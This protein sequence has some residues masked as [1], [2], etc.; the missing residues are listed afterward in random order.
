M[1]YKDVLN[2]W[3][4]IKGLEIRKSSVQNYLQCTNNWIIPSLGNVP[5]QNIKRDDLQN[6]ILDFASN[7]KHNTVINIT[8]PLFGSFKWAGENNF[9]D[10]NPCKGVKIPK[11]FSEKEINVF[12]P[13][14]IK[15]ILEAANGY[16]KDMVL[17]GYR[18]GMRIGEILVLKWEDVNFDGGFL[19]VRRTLSGYGN[20]GFEITEPKT[21]KSQRRIDLDKATLEMLNNRHAGKGIYVFS[22]RDGGIYSR[23]AINLP[24]ICKSVGLKPRSFHVLRHT[25]ATILLSAGV[26]PKIVQERLGHAKISTTLDTYSHLIPGMQNAAVEVFNNI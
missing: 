13:D 6:F 7:H 20:N 11:D 23:Q 1:L 19:T 9:I 12:S 8:K 18:T 3:L 15:R 2:K 17:L 24:K 21:K 10:I 25:H 22:K 5:I 26:H 14:E 16:K 4:E